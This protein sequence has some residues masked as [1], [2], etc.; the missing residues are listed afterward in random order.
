MVNYYEVVHRGYPENVLAM[1][2]IE[3]P[4]EDQIKGYYHIFETLHKPTQNYISYRFSRVM[5]LQQCGE[6]FGVSRQCVDESIKAGLE[7]FKKAA[8][9]PYIQYGY[10][11][12]LALEA[13]RKAKEL[14]YIQYTYRDTGRKR[15]NR[16]IEKYDGHA[17]KI[18]LNQDVKKFGYYLRSKKIDKKTNNVYFFDLNPSIRVKNCLYR[19][20]MRNPTV[21]DILN[22]IIDDPKWYKKIRNFGRICTVE[23]YDSLFNNGY[24]TKTEY[25]YLKG[26][27]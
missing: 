7:R 13:A 3:N 22:M 20:G 6:H 10:H 17:L 26:L 19:C 8:N 24:L 9:W 16:R 5:T 14:A 2:G 18:A 25:G 12:Y 21:F 4:S 1:L 11:S 15:L 27:M 23:V